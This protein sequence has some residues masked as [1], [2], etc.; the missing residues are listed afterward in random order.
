ML[1]WLRR[2]PR[3]ADVLLLTLGFIVGMN[4]L[5]YVK[6]AGVD[7]AYFYQ[8]NPAFHPLVPT[9]EGMLIGLSLAFAEYA[10]CRRLYAR[11]RYRFALFSHLAVVVGVITIVMLVVDIYLRVFRVGNDFFSALQSAWQ[12]LQSPLVLSLFTYSLILAT[13]LNFLRQISNR[14]GHNSI[15]DLVTGRYARR[16]EEHRTFMFL[17]LNQSTMIA[18][19]LGHAK[20][21]DLLHQCFN[22]LSDFLLSYDAEVYQ[23]VGD[24]VVL[25]WPTKKVKQG[26][27]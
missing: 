16:Y 23:Y 17:D 8:L 24:E 5:A 9:I 2:Y 25:T 15:V 11:F 22:D 6:F 3:E 4:F 19:Q 12:F 18:E 20:Y 26:V 10:I 27:D 14:F 13:L 1:R 21:S 7:G